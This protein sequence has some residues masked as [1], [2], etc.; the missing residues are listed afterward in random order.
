MNQPM[1]PAMTATI[2]PASRAFTMN[3]YEKSWS[4]SVTGFHESPWKIAASG[5]AVAVDERRLRLTDDDQPV[6]G[7]AQH[8]DRCA[9]EPR[10]RLA[11]DHLFA[12]PLGCVTSRQ[13]DDATQIT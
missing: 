12:G 6:V 10:E 4:R 11:R 7:R 3:G 1:T 8:L 2:V 5:M 13:V 9:V